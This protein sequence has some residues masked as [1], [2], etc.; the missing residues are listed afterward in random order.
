MGQVMRMNLKRVSLA[1]CACIAISSPTL[2]S[3]VVIDG[4]DI[5]VYRHL[6]YM[7]NMKSYNAF[8]TERLLATILGDNKIDDPERK[9]INELLKEQFSFVIRPPAGQK[10]ATR[11]V[12]LSGKLAVAAR[13]IL[14]D[15][16]PV[17][18]KAMID[19]PTSENMKTLGLWVKSSA[20]N[21]SIARD[22]LISIFEHSRTRPHH[23]EKGQ[24]GHYRETIAKYGD[25]LMPMPSHESIEAR[26]L[27]MEAAML[28]SKKNGDAVPDFLY[29]WILKMPAE[30][31]AREEV[32]AAVE[33]ALGKK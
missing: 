20:E 6:Q 1:V 21:R 32:I 8:L 22:Y 26:K 5:R 33:S 19:A 13:A 25:I 28:H 18:Y 10:S 12:H 7:S 2:A 29:S 31:D 27:V 4:L 3:D 23:K 14:K 15:A 11:D 17:D 30:F 16:G 9:L 24:W